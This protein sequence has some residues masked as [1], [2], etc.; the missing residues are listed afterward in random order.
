[1]D[2]IRCEK[3]HFY[4][5][6]RFIACPHCESI[7]EQQGSMAVTEPYRTGT[8]T[9]ILEDNG[10]Y[11]ATIVETANKNSQTQPDNLKNAIETAQKSA[12]P[13]DGQKTVGFFTNAI[14]T[15]P[16]VGWLVC[17]EGNH[18][19]EDFKL[20]SGRNFIGRSSGMDVV[21]DGDST[22]ARDRH[23]I[24]LYEPRNNIFIVQ[25]GDSKELCYL[26]DKVILTSTEIVAN[27]IISLGNTQ[28][29]FIPCCSTKFN[30]N[31]LK[32]EESE[33]NREK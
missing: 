22:I 27:D 20:K 12:M 15:E 29:M 33:N 30:W 32:D 13:E 16:V 6:E 17:T 14:G 28:L 24:I 26:N 9:D 4:D 5:A 2:L 11:T 23:A 19:G 7:N 18:F 31:D 8:L 21:L 25:P 1:M 10:D 3:G